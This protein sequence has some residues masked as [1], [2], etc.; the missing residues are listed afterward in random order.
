MKQTSTK[1]ELDSFS[2]LL[3]ESDASLQLGLNFVRD[4]TQ[5]QTSLTRLCH[6]E[7]KTTSVELLY[8]VVDKSVM[9]YLVR[10]LMLGILTIATNNIVI[11]GDTGTATPTGTVF[12]IIIRAPHYLGRYYIICLFSNI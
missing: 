4:G 8:I 5:R 2:Q 12:M 1:L 7:E 3:N 11:A 9:I 6:F 10:R